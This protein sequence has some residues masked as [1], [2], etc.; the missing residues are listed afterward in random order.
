MLCGHS[1]AIADLGICYPA[2]VSGDGKTENSSNVMDN[3]SLGNG[4]LISACTDGV[5]CVWS[6]SSGHCRRR[7][8]LPPWVGSPSIICTLPSN[9]RYVC[10]GC[11]FIDATQ[12]SHHHSFDSFEGDLV[13]EDKE[14][15]SRKHPKCTVVIVDTYGLTIIQTVFHG[16]LSI[17]P[18]KFMAVVSLGED[19][20]RHSALMVDTFGRLQLVPISKESHLEGEEGTGLHKSSSNLDMAIW[21][22]GVVEGGHLVSVATCG[23][24]IALVLK[25]CC[26]FRLLGN[27]ATIGEIAFVDNL[28][29][30]EGESTHLHATG[31]MFL[32]SGDT[33]KTGNA[34]ETHR[35]F[36]EKF[37]AWN[38]KGSAIIYA[39]SYMNDNFECQPHCE[40]PAASY[41]P[42]VRYSIRFIQMS[43]YLLRIES[44]CFHLEE[45]S[46]WRP[47]VTVWSLCQN[48]GGHGNLCQQCTRVAEGFSFVDW[49]NNSTLLHEIEGSYSEK[50]NLTFWKDTISCLDH[51]D[52]RQVD[53]G[54]DG[55]VHKRK[56]V[57]SS[58]VISENCYAPYAIVYGFF[59]GDI[60][61]LQ[62]DFVKGLNSPGTSSQLEVDSRI[63]RQCFLGH[64]GAV[65]CL[66]AHRMVGTAKGWS[67]NQ[68]LISG[69]MDCTIRIWDLVTGNLITVMHH[70]V[71][72][73]RQIIL[74]PPRTEHPWSD[75]FL[76]VGDDFSVALASL[77]T[78]RVERMFPGHP[79]YAAKVVWD[80][81]RGYIACLCQEH[82]RSSDAIDVLF[83]WDVK[84]GA[85][86]RILRGTA[87]HSMFDHFC[88][89]ISMNSI[90]GSVLNGNTSVSSL[91]L[92]THE[93]GS[94]SQSRLNND[95]RGVAFSNSTEPNTSQAHVRK[96]NSGKL[97]PNTQFGIQ[98]KKQP[99]KCSCPYPGIATLSFDLASLMFPY[100]AHESRRKNGDKQEIFNIK[101]QGTETPGPNSVPV[102]NGSDVHGM[103]SDLMEEHTPIKLLEE[104]IL[105]FSLSF[106][107]LW[108]VD[109]D[110]DRLL[111]TDMKLKRPGNFIV[112][113]GLQGEK[114]S[115][116][117]TF[118]GT[119]ASLEVYYRL[120]QI[121]DR[122]FI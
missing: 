76:S 22:N 50:I 20:Q 101:R 94:F 98:R 96:G 117:L 97:S 108:N 4:A 7:R 47:H 75:C 5:L 71:A 35:T 21:A 67:F 19:R 3:S 105:R 18:L 41:P 29:C 65:L 87:S 113:S 78:L 15:Q 73:V 44:V 36:L 46:Q 114:G 37:V 91:L 70:H 115:L 42:D 110:L 119:K 31:G 106:L 100:Q 16:N 64:T 1:A 34:S 11:C 61:V 69:S 62:F 80:G 28:F 107:H 43:L 49:V 8:K 58:M 103:L 86:E 6:R 120:F 79:N 12:L 60:E 13:S 27:G 56:I 83:I 10:V 30:L 77:E 63:S 93:D 116:T 72:P 74:S 66:A 17:G 104:Y 102:D 99:I 48:H 53:G 55:L 95:E 121:L 90:S 9:P 89:G 111:I 68:V 33:E 51:A 24:I 82:S 85:R 59:T 92:P 45:A 32:K 40:I 25:D 81:P 118:P 2:V 23:N 52:R 112:A 109:S 38:N 39:I 57:S 84:T 14:V 54:S 88:K 26:I 122:F